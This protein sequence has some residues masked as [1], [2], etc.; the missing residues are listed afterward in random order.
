MQM[1]AKGTAHTVCCSHLMKA[2]IMMVSDGATLRC[3]DPIM[4]PV[5][6]EPEPDFEIVI[7]REDNYFSSNPTPEDIILVIEIADSS[8]TY[9]REVKLPLYAEA[10]ISNYWILNLPENKL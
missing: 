10:L 5:K 6:S 1:A 8:L 3:Q 7:N 4:L 9:D 2:L